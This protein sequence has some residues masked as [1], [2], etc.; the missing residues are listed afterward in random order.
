MGVLT[1]KVT[2]LR[3]RDTQF[4]FSKNLLSEASHPKPQFTCKKYGCSMPYWAFLRPEIT[5]TF[6]N[7]PKQVTE[8]PRN[9]ATEQPPRRLGV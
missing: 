7:G 4:N 1:I 6:N 9:K 5:V 2:V 8:K 3:K